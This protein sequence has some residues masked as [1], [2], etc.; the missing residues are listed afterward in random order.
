[1]VLLGV[2]LILGSLLWRVVSGM[3]WSIPP[4]CQSLIEAWRERLS[5]ETYSLN[6]VWDSNPGDGE[7]EKHFWCLQKELPQLR[8][9]FNVPLWIGVNVFQGIDPRQTQRYL[10]CLQRRFPAIEITMLPLYG[11]SRDT[12]GDT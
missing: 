3:E 9:R 8:K 1:M 10:S 12:G 2:I 11:E 4:K 6:Y 5:S 7:L